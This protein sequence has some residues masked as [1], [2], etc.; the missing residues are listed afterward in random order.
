MKRQVINVNGP[1]FPRELPRQKEELW[2]E[3]E[4][5]TYIW[6][7]LRQTNPIQRPWPALRRRRCTLVSLW[8]Q[9]NRRVSRSPTKWSALPVPKGQYRPRIFRI[10]GQGAW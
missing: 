5:F 8:P 7:Y 1:R 2:D 6:I 4:L 9:V 10:C 3:A